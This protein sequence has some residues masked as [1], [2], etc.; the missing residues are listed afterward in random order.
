MES[1]EEAVFLHI[2]SPGG[3]ADASELLFDSIYRLSRV[4]PVF[5]VVGSV[6]ASG[7]YYLACAANRIY[8]SP[9]SLLGSIG[10]I[11]IRP[12]LT[13]LYK[14]LGVKRESLFRDPTRDLFSEAGRLSPASL[15]LM[16]ATMQS[17]YDLFLKRVAQGR[18]Q[19]LKA[20]GRQAE[21]RVFSGE[22]FQSADMIDD[23]MSLL[24]A[25]DAYRQAAG[26]PA[27]RAFRLNYYPEVRADLRSLAGMRGGLSAA[28]LAADFV[29][30]A[31]SLLTDLEELR[32]SDT[33]PILT[34][35]PW[36]QLLRDT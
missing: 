28:G 24:E 15:R 36:R 5:A 25:I 33:H 31:R 18:G 1:R 35:A 6:A 17:T 27:E 3:G 19:S 4:K 34:Y 30:G 32:L 26:Y 29:P 8:A 23:S 21:G 16:K 2:N 14:K 7:G 13:G 22:R 9:L 10:V 11:R 12:N 20:V